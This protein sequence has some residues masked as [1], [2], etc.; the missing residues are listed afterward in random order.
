MG[1]YASAKTGLIGLMHTLALELGE[2]SIRVNSV[3]PT[4]VRTPMVLCDTVFRLFRPDL[5]NPTLQ[6]VEPVLR[7]LNLLPVPY[8]EPEDVANAVLFLASDEARY[9]TGVQLPVDTGCTIK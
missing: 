5:Q 2:H 6:D 8:I 9:I 1:T 3:H 7:T 4:T